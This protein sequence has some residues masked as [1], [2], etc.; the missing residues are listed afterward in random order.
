MD[1]ALPGILS[2]RSALAECGC[3]ADVQGNVVTPVI[4]RKRSAVA[5]SIL[6]NKAE[7]IPP[8][9]TWRVEVVERTGSTNGDLM[10]RLRLQEN[11]TGIARFSLEQESGRGRLTRSW[12]SP[13]GESL[14]LSVAVPMGADS[15]QWGLIP[16][17]AGVAVART[18]EDLGG[19]ARL[20]W[21]NDVLLEGRKVCGILAESIF[22]T[23]VVGIGVN[24]GQSEDTIGF[25]QG[26]SLAMA[27]IGVSRAEVATALLTRLGEVF[28]E[29]EPQHTS[30]LGEYRRL[31][32]TIGEPVRVYLGATTTVEGIA[33]DIA[34]DGR[35]VVSSQGETAS[36]SS[37][38]VYHLR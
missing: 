25:P 6:D 2:K 14:A 5:G 32:A 30:R 31:C 11:I 10:D 9:R 38:D 4:L 27:G 3:S 13:A 28:G 12:E 23:A 18:V 17:M 16:L 7:D 8:S 24:V 29:D 36:Y 1:T 37:G 21:P 22:P 15:S 34:D 26:I 19:R 20:K 33:V 35:L